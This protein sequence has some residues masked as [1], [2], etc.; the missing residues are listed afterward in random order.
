M[1]KR[2]TKWLMFA[3]RWGIA[4]AGVWWV[5]AKTTFNDRLMILDKDNR[6]VSMSVLNAPNE[7]AARFLVHDHSNPD[8]AKHRYSVPR[9]QVWTQP[10]AT[11]V[12]IKEPS[13]VI[14]S[15]KV[16]AMRP[17]QHLDPGGTPTELL[18]RDPRSGKPERISPTRV[19]GGY[20]VRVPYPPVEIGLLR[21]VKQADLAYLLAALFV[22]PISFLIT[23]RRWHLLLGAM[24]IRLTQARTFVLN[25]VG[26]FYNTFMPGS[27]GGDLIKAYY[28]AKHT[29]HK[30]RAVLSVIV[31]RVIGLLALIV[32]GGVMATVQWQVPDCRRVAIICG[33]LILATIVG[34]AVYYHPTWRRA[35]GLS[36]LLARLPMQRHVH[37]AVEAMD[38]YGKRPVTAGAALVMTFPV[39][40][41]TIISA[42]FAGLAFGLKMNFLYYWTVV[43]VLALVGAIP[44][45]P[46]GVGV[47]E[48][49]AVLLTQKQGVPVSQAIALAM[50]IRVGQMFW[51][52]V[53]GGLFVLRGG[54]HAISEQ[55]Q[56]ELEK[57]E[58]DEKGSGFRVLGSGK[59]QEGT[60]GQR[61]QG[62]KWE[63]GPA[64]PS[65]PSSLRPFVPPAPISTSS[66][67]PVR[68]SSPKSEP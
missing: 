62:T 65:V 22:L 55:E 49:F 17:G 4:V 58:P 26:A 61:D 23:S 39:H 44:I 5:L 51:N 24:D 7:D 31:D 28:A 11:S 46:Q 2:S 9:D 63:K 52:L 41:T 68:L 25:M 59:A 3:L 33:L 32:L 37:H 13:G 18:I 12:K 35:T 1:Q 15:A 38:L 54:Y 6:L 16:L 43:P 40:M 29:T 19:V 48:G 8:P 14:E 50:S 42:Y 30:V 10:A 45:S 64:A 66:L 57:D 21:L 36:W 20:T 67:N 53:G 56:E 47:M 34:L 27:T 60:G